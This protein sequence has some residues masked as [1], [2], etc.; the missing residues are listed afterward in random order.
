VGGREKP[1]RKSLIW[2]VKHLGDF[3]TFS[4]IENPKNMKIPNFAQETYLTSEILLSWVNTI[5]YKRKPLE[6]VFGVKRTGY[7]S[8]LK[9][10]AERIPQRKGVCVWE[11][12]MRKEVRSESE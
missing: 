3:F 7:P 12:Q 2:P 8:V 4:E 6:R 9:E 11:H 5:C 1:D 10:V